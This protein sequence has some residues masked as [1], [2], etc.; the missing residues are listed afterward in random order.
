MSLTRNDNAY[1]KKRI[2]LCF[3]FKCTLGVKMMAFYLNFYKIL[4]PALGNKNVVLFLF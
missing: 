4:K 3:S 1:A 2:S